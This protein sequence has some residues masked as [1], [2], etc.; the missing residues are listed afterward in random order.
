MYCQPRP[1]G[2]REGAWVGAGKDR[3][4]GGCLGC[5]AAGATAGCGRYHVQHRGKQ[6]GQR[7][8]RQTESQPRSGSEGSQPDNSSSTSARI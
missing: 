3:Q 4:P 1:L 7:S 2:E 8:A 6:D 5:W